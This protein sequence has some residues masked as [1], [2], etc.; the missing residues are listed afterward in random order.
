MD[1]VNQIKKVIDW[2]GSKEGKQYFA[3]LC[4]IMEDLSK[5]DEKVNEQI[6]KRKENEECNKKV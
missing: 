1:I 2:L 4:F 6:E 3:K 5:I